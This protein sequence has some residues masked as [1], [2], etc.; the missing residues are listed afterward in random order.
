MTT[1]QPS[2]LSRLL[3]GIG[4]LIVLAAV[5]AG[6][7]VLLASLHMA[8]HHIPSL[9]QLGHDLKQRDNGQL[10]GAVIA[11]GVWICW[12]LFTLSLIAEI[13]AAAR[14]RPA[15]LLPG[16]AVFQRPAGVLVSAIAVGFTIG[17]LIAGVATAA[18]A[19][20]SPPPLPVASASHTAPVASTSPAPASDAS[21]APRAA[22]ATPATETAT[23]SPT[24]RVQHRDTLW[25]IA[26]D[27]LGDPMRY[28]EIIGLNRAAIGP[29]NEITPGTVLRLPADATGVSAHDTTTDPAGHTDVRVRPGDTLW[30]IEKRVTGSGANWTSAWRTNQGRVEPGGE[31]FTDP[32]L[33][34]P[35]WTLSIPT[36]EPATPPVVHRPPA[37]TGTGSDSPPSTT[38]PRHHSE[39]AEPPAPPAPTSPPGTSTP[40]AS[41]PPQRHDEHAHETAARASSSSRYESLAIGGGL[42]AAVSVAALMVHRRRKFH[43][44]RL[45]HVVASLPEPLMPLEQA[46]FA[47]G[48]PALAKMTFLDLALRSLADLVAHTPGTTLPDIAGAA[49]NDEYLELYLAAAAGD[50]PEPWLA[51]EPTRWTL[52]RGV[53]LD[54]QSR[55]RVAPYPCLVSIGYTDDGTEYL[56]DLEHTGALTLRGDTARCLDLA[57]YMVAELANNVWSDHLTVTVAGFAQELVDANPTRVAYAS[58]AHAAAQELNRVAAANREVADAAGVDVLEG[59]LRGTAGDVWMPQVLL[60]APDELAGDTEF[61]GV[62]GDEGR[63]AVAVVLTAA[64]ESSPASR[65]IIT[66]TD[67]G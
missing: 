32:N 29:D 62:G 54:A 56:L 50:P 51:S 6:V 28:P 26:E 55:R 17:P 22:P 1:G 59:R 21:H 63:S 33:I 18:R 61:P 36:D 40:T 30:E 23:P 57:R 58:D 31:R 7:P 38:P 4:A 12:A 53:D 14:K 67:N 27:H 11:A 19:D 8:P 5:V 66:V 16:L 60:S 48:R 35:G 44:R 13:F 46:L 25:K 37:R 64:R 45:G 52:S 42:L 24:Y 43:R 2:R 34:Q 9:H 41:A 39:P 20:A 65:Q 47:N 15:R 3:R 49:V 10:A